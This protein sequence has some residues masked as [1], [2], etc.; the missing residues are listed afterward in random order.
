MHRLIPSGPLGWTL[1]SLA[2]E[3][4]LSSTKLHFG[5]FF[6]WLFICG[7]STPEVCL[8]LQLKSATKKYIFLLWLFSKWMLFSPFTSLYLKC[9]DCLCMVYN[10]LPLASIYNCYTLHFASKQSCLPM[11]YLLRT[12]TE[13][14]DISLFILKEN[15]TLSCKKV[16]VCTPMT[17]ADDRREAVSENILVE[18]NST[19]KKTFNVCVISVF[20]AAW[21]NSEASSRTAVKQPTQ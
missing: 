8:N 21:G 17:A 18:K 16:S 1:Y 2:L 11:P 9:L 10:F 13:R 15:E 14:W 3:S 7:T 6:F 5:F 19:Q 12:C 4:G 20:K